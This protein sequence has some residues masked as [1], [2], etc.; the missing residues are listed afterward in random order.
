MKVSTLPS[1]HSTVG[2]MSAW[3]HIVRQWW[4]ERSLFQ[5]PPMSAHRYV[6][7]N[8]SAA[9]PAT[10]R[11]AGVAPQVNLTLALKPRQSSMQGVCVAPQNKTNLLDKRIEK[12]STEKSHRKT[13]GDFSFFVESVGVV[14][15]SHVFIVSF[16]VGFS[17]SS[18]SKKCQLFSSHHRLKRFCRGVVIPRSH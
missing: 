3:S 16:I 12:L 13:S 2:R 1:W 7:E 17:S 11:S 9:M 6:E 8:G 4:H 15:L 10:N 18:E 14:Q 5:A